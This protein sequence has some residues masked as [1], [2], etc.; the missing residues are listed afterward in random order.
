MVTNFG[1][2][3]LNFIDADELGVG[4][5]KRLSMSEW[6]EYVNMDLCKTLVIC[7]FV[8]FSNLDGTFISYLVVPPASI[9][10]NV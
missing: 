6:E 1:Y 3:L 4:K 2:F 7:H 9:M 5:T 10:L 8:E